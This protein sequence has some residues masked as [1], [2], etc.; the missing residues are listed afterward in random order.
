M[1][2]GMPLWVFVDTHDHGSQMLTK[3]FCWGSLGSLPGDTQW[4]CGCQAGYRDILFLNGNWGP[5][6]TRW[7]RDLGTWFGFPNQ[8]LCFVSS[9]CF[10]LNY[11]PFHLCEWRTITWCFSSQF[12]FISIWGTMR[13]SCPPACCEMWQRGPFR[14]KLAAISAI[15]LIFACVPCRTEFLLCTETSPGNCCKTKTHQSTKA[16]NERLNSR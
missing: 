7:P 8:F 16:L 3:T 9:P 11:K 12:S 14:E 5:W 1:H 15:M 2:T 6:C 4:L 10:S 13:C